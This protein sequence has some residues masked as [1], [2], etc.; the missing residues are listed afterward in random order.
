MQNKY[1]YSDRLF[2]RLAKITLGKIETKD[3]AKLWK[4]IDV[5]WK[6]AGSDEPKKLEVVMKAINS[7]NEKFPHLNL[8][9]E[10]KGVA[11]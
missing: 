5:N 4:W 10:I 11:A 7:A 6:N 1:S 3:H 2:F 8:L 9:E